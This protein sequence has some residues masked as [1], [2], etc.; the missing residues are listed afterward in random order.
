MNRFPA[1]PITAVADQDLA[2][3]ARPGHGIP[4]QDPDPS[5]QFPQT[6]HEAGRE[7]NSMLMAG[8]L[9]AGVATG[10]AIGVMVAGPAGA[11]VGAALGGAA[12]G[13]GGA[14]AGAAVTTQ[15]ADAADSAPA[16]CD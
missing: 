1:L 13:L 5:A 12:G 7:A 10:V 2:D 15:G 11:A 9:M 6:R 3:Q 8:G 4:S 16:P 14:A